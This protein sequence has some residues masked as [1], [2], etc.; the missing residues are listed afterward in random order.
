M[1]LTTEDELSD[2]NEDISEYEPSEFKS[3]TSSDSEIEETYTGKAATMYTFLKDH[4]LYTCVR[5]IKSSL[6]NK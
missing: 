5:L 3:D 6:T 2:N 1:N 4:P